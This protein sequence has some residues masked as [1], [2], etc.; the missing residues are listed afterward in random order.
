MIKEVLTYQTTISLG[1]REQYTDKI[2]NINEVIEICQEYCDSIG[3]CVT[4][5]PTYFIYTEGRE[6]GCFIGLINYPR[7]PSSPE[8]IYKKAYNLTCI[9]KERFNQLKVSIIYN[10]KTVM[11]E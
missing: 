10:D 6:D 2:H 8:D 5:T 4:V 3:L 1:L 9:L 7:F 11:I